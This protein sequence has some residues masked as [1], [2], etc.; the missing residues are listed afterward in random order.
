MLRRRTRDLKSESPEPS[1]AGD[2]I[3]MPLPLHPLRFL[4]DPDLPLLKSCQV[5]LSPSMQAGSG[6]CFVQW[7]RV[8]SCEFE[9]SGCGMCGLGSSIF[10]AAELRRS[11]GFEIER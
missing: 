4:V 1:P 8:G 2:S 3:Y 9:V 11:S 5:N 10:E 6:L 7:F